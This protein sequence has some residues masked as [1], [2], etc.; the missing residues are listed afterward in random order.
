M[1]SSPVSLFNAMLEVYFD[2]NIYNHI[3]KR[4][5]GVTEADIA[6]LYTA[7]RAD[8]IRILTS[9]PVIEEVLSALLC[10]ERDG[11]AI[12]MH[13]RKLAKR[14]RIIKYHPDLLEDDIIAYSRGRKMLSHFMAPPPN[15]T[16]IFTDHGPEHMAILRKIA[17][18][19][20]KQIQAFRG[21]MDDS[22]NKHIR[23]LAE[24]IK[25][26]KQQQS[27]EDYWAELSVPFTELLAQ[28]AGV[29]AECQ[30]RGMEGLLQV[31]SVR[32]CTLAQLS[33]GYSNT[34]QRTTIDRGDSRDMH[35]AVLASSLNAFVTHDRRFAGILRRMPVDNFE[36]IDLNTLLSRIQ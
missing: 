15:F 33:L 12:L 28:K 2:T 8:K 21:K 24:D 4:H 22:Y 23:P 36:V 19:T 13:I 1:T 14:K 17:G 34:Y 10:S 16:K 9:T 20:Q 3:H 30:A 25:R 11:L 5:H 31:R 35:H 29:L 26:Q 6:K 18:D 27:F 7:V 32:L